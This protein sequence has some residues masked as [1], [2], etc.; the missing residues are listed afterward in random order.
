MVTRVKV[1][2]TARSGHHGPSH[3]V[4]TLAD[5]R[6]RVDGLTP[7]DRR[8]FLRRLAGAAKIDAP[9]RR[10]AAIE[11]I[12]ADL[13]RV[14]ARV[15][16]RRAA[17]PE[18]FTYPADL[19]IT[20]HLDEL[21]EVIRTNQV[22]IVS[23]ETGSGKSTQIPKL[24]LELGRGVDG[25][26][27]HTQPRRIAARSIAER[28][29]EETGTR[30]G[31]LVGYTVRF[32][33]RVGDDTLIR[34]MTDGIVLSEIHRDR[35]LAR[36]DTLIVDEA[37]ERS[38]N[39]DFLL[40]Y[41]KALLP[42]RPD[43][44]VI[45]TSATIDTERF[46]EHFGGA[47]VVEVSGRAYPVEVRYRP[48]DD[49]EASKPR[50]QPQAIADAVVELYTESPGD[51]LVFCS[52]ERE[53][54][55]AAD[56]LADLHLA[57][58]QVLPLYG[59]LSAAE[60]HRVFEPHRG[61][62]VI[63]AT[64]VAET[65]LTVPGVR[66]VVD[67]GTARISRYSRRTKVQRL[68]IEP[69]SRA[70]ADQRAG[71]CGRLGPGVCIRL[72]TEEDYRSRPAFT[73]PEIRRTNLASV[74]LQMAALDLG[75]I[76]AFGFLDPPESRSIRDG[77]ALLEEL[78]AVNP[79]HQGTRRWLTKL[80]RRLA[81][82]PLDVR[83]ARM[84][85][86]A[87]RNGCLAE[88]AVIAAALSVRDPRERPVEH[89]QHAD[90]LHARFKH[91]D[92]D[93]LSWLHLWEYL[94][95]ERRARTSNQF[96]RMCRD[97]FLNERRIRE[98]QHIHAQ[99]R[100]VTEELG[101]TV[102]TTPADPDAIHR[103]VL[104]GL[105]SHIGTK[106]PDGYE[107]RGARSARF[108]I[109][110]GST[111]FKAAPRWVMAAEL[112][113]TSRLWARG[114]A[115]IRPEWVERVGAHLV[116]T[117]Y[118]DPW[119]DADRGAAVAYETVTIY[120]LPLVTDRSVQ[121]GR[122]DPAGARELFIS[123]AL[124]A[125]EW[126]THHDF[127]A[128][129]EAMIEQ[130]LALEARERR[131][132]LLVDDGAIFEFFDR[133]VPGD[134]LS[135]RHFDRWWKD[136]RHDDPHL[137]DLGLDDLIDAAVVA[138]DTDAFPDVWHHGDV[139]MALMYA[140]EPGGTTDGVTVDVPIGGLDRVDPAVF[141]W[142]VPGYR[143]EL[144]TEL[145]RT[146][147]KRLRKPF[148]PIPDTARAL[149]ERLGPGDGRLLSA[150]RRELTRIGG[151][152]IPP[153]AFDLD[154]LPSH[155]RPTFRVVDDQGEPVAEGDDLAVL[156]AE[157]R[158]AA[159]AM[160]ATT[161]ELEQIG[162]TTWSI[163]ALPRVVEIGDADRR[164]RAYPALV[165]EGGSVAV[166]LLAT[167][168]EQADA[169]WAGTA[170]LLALNLPSAGKML[171]L[172]L[173][174]D[175]KRAIRSG[176]HGAPA[177]WVDDCLTCV[178]G[179]VIA[180]AGGPPFDGV[181]FDAL[182]ARA[183]EDLDKRVEAVGS[184]SLRILGLARSLRTTLGRTDA[185]A[186]QVAVADMQGQLDQLIY[187]GFLTAVG[188]SR[189]VDVE[190]YLRAIERRLERLVEN[191]QRDRELMTRVQRLEGEYERLCEALAPSPEPAEIAWMLQ[192]LRVSLFAQALGTR[193][194]VSEQRIAK[195]LEAL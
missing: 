127:A 172:L 30:V 88:V 116:R 173:T 159:R 27:G 165:D 46:S 187:P 164:V 194:K 136:A 39:I 36:Y 126:E 133:R 84:V 149:A 56:A 75:G 28:I 121:Y 29:A 147:P 78:G 35:R 123:H 160:P 139:A 17:V 179:Q 175:A 95:T 122:I 152:P 117:S 1:A 79:T 60:Q 67:V 82:F 32:T 130:V 188:A 192:E 34:V 24:C 120:G 129:N 72:Y 191:P 105:L 100:D 11:T 145:I 81:R 104:A 132:D 158:D 8:S 58:T 6:A 124:V 138:P 25:F 10:K 113:E 64:N 176:P 91:P 180:D 110:P 55:D 163:G 80:G 89:R 44:K 184:A 68:P 90:Q 2:A 115:P 41:L 77:I 195:A 65:S 135:V 96:R 49:P 59:R 71:R 183:R 83:L 150:L 141:E 168:D 66:S 87:D 170:R 13:S 57:H 189:L 92:S 169:M 97:E 14:E 155:L 48:L 154:V 94:Q 63:I 109:A 98:W 166:R 131:T 5:L 148:V 142:H 108:F 16:R 143:V 21:G 45:I 101:M 40:G 70:S 20:E 15:A 76:E 118:S 19:P 134:V 103:S 74:I 93:L 22:V 73:E 112:V 61:R 62:R 144:L 193:G 106:D 146:L 177:E 186:P 178:A 37:H 157:L 99:L 47:P 156:K 31:G 151:V 52:G 86:E 51:I 190:R 26:I 111:L 161:H 54:R 43:L 4:M 3:R 128:H 12:A 9:A 102:N 119:W 153:D 171:R 174:A 140:F 107:Y 167:A 125:G 137:L 53:I 23:G 85:I 162:L 42:R 33:D 181:G 50:D 114:V 69:I 18:K 7:A 182:V 38:L 185:D